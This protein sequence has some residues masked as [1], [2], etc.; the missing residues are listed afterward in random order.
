MGHQ[1]NERTKSTYLGALTSISRRSRVDPEIFV[2]FG[3]FRRS[4]Q[5][6]FERIWMRLDVFG[7]VRKCWVAFRCFLMF[8]VPPVISGQFWIILDVLE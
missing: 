4:R 5:F 2:K 7:C 8:L 3:V 6:V 1:M